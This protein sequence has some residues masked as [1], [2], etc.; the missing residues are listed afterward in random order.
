LIFL[1]FSARS[2]S[3][4]S[5]LLSDVSDKGISKAFGFGVFLGSGGLA[6]SGNSIFDTQYKAVIKTAKYRN[7][8]IPY[9]LW[10]SKIPDGKNEVP[11]IIGQ[12]KQ[13]FYNVFMITC[14]LLAGGSSTRFGSPKAL[15]SMSGDT[16][17]QH[18]QN[19]LLQSSCD[20]I[21]VVLGDHAHQ[22]MPSIFI[23]NRIR[24]VYNK[25]YNLGQIS[26]VQEGWRQAEDSSEGVMFLP[27]DCPLVQ[28]SSIDKVIHHF[29]EFRSDVLIPSYQNKKG[30]PPIF[31]QRLKPK[32]LDL[33]MDQGLNSLFTDHLPQTI[34]IDD[35]GI[36]KSFNTPQEL[37]NILSARP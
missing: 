2:I 24:V 35:S 15:A 12:I 20:N 9:L 3:S 17:I 13:L 30:H 31:H 14:V 1:F 32:A 28:A 16:V 11:K 26:S 29:K 10:L 23:H 4:F 27:V 25:H 6:I 22:I 33:A 18:V 21:I 8:D 36:V 34:E 37:E 5:V 7:T 19:T